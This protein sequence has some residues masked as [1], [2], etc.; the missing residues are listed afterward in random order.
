MNIKTSKLDN[1][2]RIAELNPAG[3]LKKIGVTADSVVVDYG[4]GSG[5]FSIAAAQM[6]KEL[7]YAYDIDESSLEEIR[8]KANEQNIK[9]IIVLNNEKMQSVQ[10]GMAADF[11]LLST[12]YHE[13]ADKETLFKNI[14]QIIKD[15]GKAA[16]IEFQNKETP[17]GPPLKRRVGLED[18]TNDFAEHGFEPGHDYILGDNFYLIVFSRKSAI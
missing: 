12:V 1:P 4:A 16:V 3:T 14:K 7:V 13:I 11:V 10:N 17:M 18:L 9:N 2:K 8:R 5:V 6:T 15:T